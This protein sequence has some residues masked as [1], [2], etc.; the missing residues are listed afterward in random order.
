M[1]SVA[2]GDRSDGPPAFPFIVGS[3]RS[4]TTL[5]RLMVDAHPQIAIPGESYFVARLAWRA[6]N[7]DTAE[8]FDAAGFLGELFE[9]AWF[10]KWGL[11]SSAVREAFAAA[12]VRDLA[13]AIRR[14]YATYAASQGKSRYGDKTPDYVRQIGILSGLFP[15][16]RFVHVIRDGRDVA[17]SKVDVGLSS[18]TYPEAALEWKARVRIGRLGGSQLGPERYLE[19]RYESL[20]E[21]PEQVLRSICGFIG[22]PFDDAMLRYVDEA[23]KIV[24]A[25]ADVRHTR[26]VLPPT[27]GLRDWRTQMPRRDL[28]VTELLVGDMLSDLGYPSSGVKPTVGARTEAGRIHA[29]DLA[30][31]ARARLR[32]A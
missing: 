12:P 15:E 26:S 27:K 17:L 3:E 25:M 4:G 5:L 18:G 32:S 11:P 2:D 23:P 20:I 21:S 8:G 22:L 30:R 28:M 16:S 9:H 10:V 6:R 24:A 1:T 13:D 19:V 7:F 31:R 29:S 14:V